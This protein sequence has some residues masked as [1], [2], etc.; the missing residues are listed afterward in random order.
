M[1]YGVAKS[2][3]G[4]LNGEGAQ[5]KKRWEGDE[6]WDWEEKMYGR[7]EVETRYNAWLEEM[8]RRGS[9]ERRSTEN[10]TLGYVTSDVRCNSFMSSIVL[11]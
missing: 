11:N 4:A 10:L 3:L 9:I 1:N 6:E 7:G 2:V 8:A 5:E